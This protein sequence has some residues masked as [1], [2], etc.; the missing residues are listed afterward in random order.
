[1]KII[2]LPLSMISGALMNS[3]LTI[4][5]AKKT[6]FLEILNKNLPFCP[7]CMSASLAKHQYLYMFRRFCG[8]ISSTNQ[9][10]SKPHS[11]QKQIFAVFEQKYTLLSHC[12][13]SHALPNKCI[14]LEDFKTSYQVLINS[15]LRHTHSKNK[16]V[17][18]LIKMYPFIPLCT[19]CMSCQTLV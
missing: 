16:F 7:L 5:I 12:A 15:F 10:V 18:F 17:G 6:I 11:K 13:W 19:C 1:M 2:T 4:F 8:I 9:P 3:F 14:S